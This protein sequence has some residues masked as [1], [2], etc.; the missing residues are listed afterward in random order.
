MIFGTYDDSDG[1]GMDLPV[2]TYLFKVNNR[3]TRKRCEICLKLTI[4][5]PGR[6]HCRRSGNFIVYFDTSFSSVSIIDFKQVN[7]NWT[8]KS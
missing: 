6:R 7:V 5:A 2:S 8:A 3:N 4:K 1:N